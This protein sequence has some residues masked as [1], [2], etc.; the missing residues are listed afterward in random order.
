MESRA[1][2][3][4]EVAEALDMSR[5]YVYKLIR[6]LN[7]EMEEGGTSPCPGGSAARTSRDARSGARGIPMSVTGDKRNGTWYVQA[8][9]KTYDGKRAHKVKR[10][11]KTKPE[12]LTRERDFY[13]VQ[14]DDIDMKLVDFLELYKRDVGP[15]LNTW[16]TK[17]SIITKRILP[18][19]GENRTNQIA[20]IDIVRW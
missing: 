19:L 11:F 17:E 4:D 10:G 3:A 5:A 1:I 12:A 14:A 6:R 13:A 9:Y 20:P 2:G 7:K 18:Y 8:W 15:C 16:K